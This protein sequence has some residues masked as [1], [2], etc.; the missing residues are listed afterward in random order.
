MGL[1]AGAEASRKHE[2]LKKKR[3]SFPTVTT[4]VKPTD[5]SRLFRPNSACQHF[6]GELR[7][8][9]CWTRFLRQDKGYKSITVSS[10]FAPLNSWSSEGLPWSQEWCAVSCTGSADALTPL[11]SFWELHTVT[12]W[13]FLGYP[14]PENSRWDGLPLSE[15]QH[16]ECLGVHQ[17]NIVSWVTPVSMA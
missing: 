11:F 4:A 12:V 17:V 10:P 13:R 3:P 7:E 16:N 5:W 15:T 9:A 6:L 1:G 14:D 8:F 2:E